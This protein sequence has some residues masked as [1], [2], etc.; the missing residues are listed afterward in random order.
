[1]NLYV[2]KYNNY[3]NRIIKREE[4]LQGYGEP[5]YSLPNVL[6]FNLADGVN[7]TQTINTNAKGDYCILTKYDNLGNE[8]IDSRWFIVE[9]KYQRNGQWTLSLRRDLVA[10]NYDIV[11]NMPAF[12]EKA[13][14]NANDPAIFNN[15]NMTFNRIKTSETLLQDKTKSAWVVG[16]VPKDSFKEK[17][18]VTTDIILEGSAD[19]TVD[20]LSDLPFAQY[21][22]NYNYKG[23]PYNIILSTLIKYLRQTGGG[24][25]IGQLPTTNYYLCNYKFDTGKYKSNVDVENL[26]FES[27]YNSKYCQNWSSSSYP[28]SNEVYSNISQYF[29]NILQQIYSLTQANSDISSQELLA[30]NGK[31]VY[32]STNKTYYRINISSR[33]ITANNSENLYMKI[34]SSS[35]LASESLT[36]MI[37]S[38]DYGSISLQGTPGADSYSITYNQ[39]E[40]TVSL[41]Q[42]AISSSV[43]I[44]NDR[45]HLEDQP[46]DMFCIP[47]SDTLPIYKNGTKLF[48]ANKSLATGIAVAIGANTGKDN[49]YDIQLLPYCPISSIQQ[50]EAI[51]I[52]NYKV[53]YIKQNDVNVGVV[54][55]ATSSSFTVNIDKKIKVT[56]YKITNEC[57]MYRL[58]S[59]NYNGQFEFNPAK[60]NGV[61]GFTASCTYKPFNPYIKV[62]PIFNRLYGKDFNDARGLICQGDFSLPQVSNAWANYQLS[63]KNYENMFNRE[64]TNMEI[65]NKYQNIQTLVGG[66]AG[67]GSGIVA[68]G[69]LGGVGG[70]IAGG[71]ASL[72]GA[73]AD[74]AIQKT[75][76]NEAL[77]YKKDMFGYQLG[78]I[79]AMPSSLAKTSAINIDNKIFPIIEYYTCTEQEKQALRDKIYWN[80][81]TVGRIGTIKEFLQPT[82]S[83][84]KAQ[85]IRFSYL[86]DDT[87]YLNEI[88]NEINK[89]VF[90]K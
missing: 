1:M 15:E 90:I 3:Y 44:D 65:N 71:L 10:D 19:I 13:T 73:G 35:K 50:D 57:D 72:V 82:F 9:N 22:D 60:N 74:Y 31:I 29:N 32:D 25:S 52:G 89:G 36:P 4:T 14:V 68:G 34:A 80:G 54:L 39:K 76:Q 56:D 12:I 53:D 21:I 88:A 8:I 58:V 27:T 24:G 18:T 87:N 28:S 59:P 30:Y 41:N 85:I 67:A 75:L 40:Y 61:T 64:V 16:Y 33:N 11:L 2:F 66:V 62:A 47:Y 70:A 79:K 78:N 81:M 42:L 55:W 26:Y 51:D 49:V 37:N 23:N 48:N 63:N 5:L 38:V 20:N 69:A 86:Y 17:T 84:I 46:F 77:D 83:Y 7:T 43:V 6:N 45:Y